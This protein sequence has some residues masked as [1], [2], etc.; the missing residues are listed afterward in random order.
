YDRPKGSIG[1]NHRFLGN[2]DRSLCILRLTAANLVHLFDC[3]LEADG[4]KPKNTSLD[5]QNQQSSDADYERRSIIPTLIFSFP[6]III[7]FLLTLLGWSR[8][9]DKRK[10]LSAAIIGSG[11]FL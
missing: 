8:F 1:R 10:I 4:L 5:K 11:W 9:D 6:S 2:G 3:L 7:G